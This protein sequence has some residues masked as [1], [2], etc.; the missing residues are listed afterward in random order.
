MTRRPDNAPR[1]RGVALLMA[2][3]V[4]MLLTLFMSEY[5]FSMGL[6]LRSMTTFKESMQARNLARAAFKAV[7]TG[8]RL[9][10]AVFFQGY[11]RMSQL[12]QVASLP[13]EDGLLVALRITPLDSL[14]NINDLAKIRVGTDQ[15]LVNRIKFWNTL[16]DLQ[17][18]AAE[19]DQPPEAL[20]NQTISALYAALH[21]WVDSDDV[22]YTGFSGVRGAEADAYFSTEPEVAIK[23]VPLDRL[24]EIR[25]VRGVA[26]SRIPWPVWEDRFCG[27]PSRTIK[28]D[29][30]FSERI[31]VNRAT[32]EEI[33]RF[34][35][36]HAFEGVENL[37]DPTI[38]KGI[39][40]YVDQ[41]EQIATLF[42]P[43]EGER[44]IYNKSSMGQALKQLGFD[45]NYGVNYLFST[46]DQWYRVV[47]TTE[48]N[49]VQATLKALVHVPR[50]PET[51]IGSKVEVPW[52]SLE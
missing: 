4:V 47:L 41:A 34:L 26:D 36:Y 33:I 52:W 49:G 31:N 48:V 37:A 28:S 46:V 13:L 25:L 6:E 51:R 44:Q 29:E 22:D 12:L 5:F 35:N 15:D 11:D 17:V 24:T 2:L 14:F 10:E 21:D 50:N 38:Q 16:K 39:N 9:D 23:N 40:A 32:S 20:T 30:L 43:L 27:L 42:A 18:P 7:I 45:D 19:P 8:L 1:P 3:S